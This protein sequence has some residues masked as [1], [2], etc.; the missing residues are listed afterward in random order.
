LFGS[1]VTGRELEMQVPVIETDRLILRPLTAEDAGAAFVWLSD[2]RVT[3]FMPY[4]T[5]TN[6]GDVTRWIE[7]LKEEES[8]HFGFVL[9]DNNLF[10][11]S[12][13]IGYSSETKTW[14]FG[15][16]IRYD[17]WNKGLSTEAARAMIRFAFEKLGARDFGANHATEN[18]ASG[19]VIEKCGLRFT[20]YGEYSKF[21]HSITFPAKFYEA[22]LEELE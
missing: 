5:Y 6:T 21:D 7:S 20:R 16:N 13:D 14:E 19:R 15:Y 17:Y 4:P 22:H 3:K 1:K 10:I 11:G 12:G 8:Y 9:K 18:G 2:E